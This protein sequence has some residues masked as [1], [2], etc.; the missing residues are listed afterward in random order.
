MIPELSATTLIKER[1]VIDRILGQGGFGRTYLASDKQKNNYC[2]L[3]E[4]A[5]SN[6]KPEAL[7]K[8]RELFI[9]EAKILDKC[10][11][12][13]IPEFVEWFEDNDRLFIVQEFVN[14]KTYWDL[15]LQGQTFAEK[16]IVQWLRD[17]LEV[18]EYIHGKG[19]IHRDISPDNIML[20]QGKS[21][22]VLIDFGVV[23]YAETQLISSG[24]FAS[25]SQPTQVGKVAYAPSEQL[26]GGEC[27]P[28]SDLY[29]LAVTA[30]VLLTGKEPNTL[31]NYDG[32][33]EWRS[34]VNVSDKLAIIV[35][36]M[37][38]EKP[39][40][41]YQSARD[42]LNAIDN[43][44]TTQKTIMSSSE[45]EL[46]QGAGQ[47]STIIS[48]DSQYTGNSYQSV[49]YPRAQQYQNRDNSSQW[50]KIALIVLPIL[51]LVGGVAALESPRIGFLCRPLNNCVADKP[52]NESYNSAVQ[53]AAGARVLG[54]NAQTVGD[55]QAARDRMKSAI[56][57]LS[58]IPPTAK[59]YPDTQKLLPSY[60]SELTGME[61]HLAREAQAEKQLEAAE[62]I[63]ENAP[64]EIEL[65]KQ[66]SLLIQATDQLKT[67]A[68][69]SLI[70]DKVK[71]RLAE[72]ERQIQDIEN[73]IRQAP[74]PEQAS[75][76]PS[77]PE[78]S[79]SEATPS[80]DY[81]LFKPP[82]DSSELPPDPKPSPSL[83]DA[84]TPKDGNK[85]LF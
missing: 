20:P 42:V 39:S 22:P 17:I 15:R 71:A 65:S 21:K 50:K 66:K 56:E 24:G 26:R 60:Q 29:A 57:R 83:P 64:K 4:F 33:W 25:S 30:I 77:T 47:D 67:I 32:D 40:D 85:T 41:R 34:H 5:P 80:P 81:D 36:K 23:K 12:R 6:T 70:A 31:R 49:N 44:R 59:V 13:Q 58:S 8:A 38:Q 35:D 84:P 7:Q 55:L 62:A 2:V 48:T 27:Y 53:Q 37:L 18:L 1:Y 46:S 43:D 82:S 73:S 78:P 19:I 9:R 61:V 16:D 72:W 52:F 10:N 28:N 68:T 76:E 45:T 54:Q 51:F 14:G 3:K 79:S 11:H 74:S 75:P 69:D 63:A